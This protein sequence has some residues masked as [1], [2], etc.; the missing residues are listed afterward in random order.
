MNQDN[1]IKAFF[2]ANKPQ[3][4]EGT[5]FMQKL[6]DRIEA[7]E[8][9]KQYQLKATRECYR[10]AAISMFL[11]ILLGGGLWFCLCFLLFLF[12]NI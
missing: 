7:L 4:D 10:V 12:L 11:G 3:T 5:Q 8:Q 9:V 1:E 6:T 2:Q